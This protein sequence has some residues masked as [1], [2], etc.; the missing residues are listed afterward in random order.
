MCAIF[1]L[2][3][4]RGKLSLRRRAA[5]VRELSIAA[6]ARGTDA[7]GIAWAENG[8]I[9]IQKAPRPARRMHYRIP[10]PARVIMGHTRMATQ[11]PASRNQNNH[12]FFG[13]TGCGP[14]ALAH[15]GIIYNDAFLRKTWDLPKTGVETDSYVA[16][17]LLERENAVSIHTLAHVAEQL[18]G[19]FT[20]TV[21]DAANNLYFVKGNNPLC[22]FHFP[23]PGCY[24][25]A[26][27]REILEDALRRL[28]LCGKHAEVPV[29]QGEILQIDRSGD[30]TVGR[31]NDG[32]LI[33]ACPPVSCWYLDSWFASLYGGP[34]EAYLDDVFC[35]G[36][37]MGVPSSELKLLREA[38]YG[39]AELEELLYDEPWRR[40]CVA[41]L[42]GG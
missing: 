14:F 24:L 23:D 18:E 9:R 4:Y 40:E 13:R 32:K 17:Q 34:E 21:L 42:Y 16:V 37:Q 7:T 1:G 22:I 38:G 30:R 25:Y 8:R 41:E 11:G 19:S 20:I 12:P 31:F 5:I 27:T 33:S 26:S 10:A 35:Y 3:D 2:L 29:K 15:N 28:H 6:Q 39:A 36:E